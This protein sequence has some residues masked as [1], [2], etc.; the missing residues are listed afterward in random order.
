MAQ[1][2][3]LSKQLE[4]LDLRI[5]EAKRKEYGPALDEVRETIVAFG[6]SITEVFGR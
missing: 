3:E 5:E 2:R 6:F 1:Y 4:Q